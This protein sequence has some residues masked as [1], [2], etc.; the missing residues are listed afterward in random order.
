MRSDSPIEARFALQL[1]ALKAPE[2]ERNFRFHPDRRWELDFA[3][4]EDRFAVEI[5]GE[6]HRIKERFHS[7]IEKHATALRMGWKI[8]RLDGRAVRAGAGVDWALELLFRAAG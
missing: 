5:D 3:W 2:W 6:V 1:R 4:P 7:D 8:L